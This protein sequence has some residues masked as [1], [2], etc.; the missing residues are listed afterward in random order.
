MHGTLPG[1]AFCTPRH[2]QIPPTTH[3]GPEAKEDGTTQAVGGVGEAVQTKAAGQR[4]RDR[5]R[6]AVGKFPEPAASSAPAA[7]A[8]GKTAV[9]H[10][11]DDDRMTQALKSFHAVLRTALEPASLL[12]PLGALR[13]PVGH[14]RVAGSG[15][16]QG[17]G[18]SDRNATGSRC[19]L[20]LRH[21]EHDADGASQ[22][23]SEIPGRTRPVL[24]WVFAKTGIRLATSWVTLTPGQSR[25][26]R[27]GR[28][29]HE[30]VPRQ[31]QSGGCC[32]AR[33]CCESGSW[34]WMITPCG[35]W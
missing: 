6:G 1:N 35:A 25:E 33:A 19:T 14:E 28:P 34:S 30:E 23:Y 12:D 26:L 11:K 21:L 24:T 3:E 2:D 17:V 16:T 15:G 32:G 8:A 20:Q 18:P 10:P 31:A 13:R 7:S 9:A 5:G 4:R 27:A 29:F 22:T